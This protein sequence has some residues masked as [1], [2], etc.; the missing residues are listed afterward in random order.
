MHL[1]EFARYTDNGH[2]LKKLFIGVHVHTYVDG[3]T[4]N[5]N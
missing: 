2:V 5:S 1:I 4:N 3:W